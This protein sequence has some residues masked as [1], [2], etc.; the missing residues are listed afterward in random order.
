MIDNQ[1]HKRATLRRGR[2]IRRIRYAHNA[3]D[4]PVAGLAPKVL[5][6]AA[7]GGCP[8]LTER[9][10]LMNLKRSSDAD[11]AFCFHIRR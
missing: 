2:K 3:S 7:F 5:A 8:D 10:L 11:P 9:A 1:A 6:A 4:V